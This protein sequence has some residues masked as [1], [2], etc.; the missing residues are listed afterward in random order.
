MLFQRLTYLRSVKNAAVLNATPP[1]AA[2]TLD[3][4]PAMGATPQAFRPLQEVLRLRRAEDETFSR[5]KVFFF[6]PESL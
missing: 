5:K 2:T 3:A 4:A 6:L 1:T